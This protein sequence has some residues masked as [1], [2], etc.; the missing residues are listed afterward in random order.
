M[1]MFSCKHI[2]KL[3]FFNSRWGNQRF[4]LSLLVRA[5]KIHVILYGFIKNKKKHVTG[6]R[7]RPARRA[8]VARP[9]RSRRAPGARQSGPGACPVRS[10]HAP[11]AGP[12]LGARQPVQVPGGAGSECVSPIAFEW[13]TTSL[14]A[15][16]RRM[17]RISS[18]L[19]S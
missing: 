10:R 4:S 16:P 5:A 18:D 12:Q 11:G 1:Q 15:I 6:A 13:K 14:A 19:R 9:A 8:P 17:H 7:P 3:I 2:K